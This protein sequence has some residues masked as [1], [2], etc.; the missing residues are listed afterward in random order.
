MSLAKLQN[1]IHGF[2]NTCLWLL[3]PL[4]SCLLPPLYIKDTLASFKTHEIQP[5][6]ALKILQKIIKV[7][8]ICILG[9][10]LSQ[11]KQK[12]QVHF[13]RLPEAFAIITKS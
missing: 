7:V 5:G 6:K 9:S 4:F 8:K 10:S 1:I 13:W 12:I 11:S 2:T 3:L